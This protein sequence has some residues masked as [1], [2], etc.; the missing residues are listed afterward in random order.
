MLLNKDK[1]SEL[2]IS[3]ILLFKNPELRKINENLAIT[4]QFDLTR[5]YDVI[6]RNSVFLTPEFQIP[7][8]EIFNVNLITKFRKRQTKLL[9]L[10]KQ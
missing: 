2:S 8:G 5:F 1:I 6:I 9:K 4:S 3:E 10:E 7:N